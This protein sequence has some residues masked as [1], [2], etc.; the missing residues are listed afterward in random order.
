V[1]G[2]WH[3]C[4]DH[5]ELDADQ[6]WGAGVGDRVPRVFGVAVA[7]DL[8]RRDEHIVGIYSLDSSRRNRAVTG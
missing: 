5:V 4:G 1:G 2:R 7:G 6:R 3:C 8:T